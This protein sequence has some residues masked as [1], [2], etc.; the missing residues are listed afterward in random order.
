MGD[1]LG[2]ATPDSARGHGRHGAQEDV[3]LGHESAVAKVISCSAD[4]RGDGAEDAD[5]GNAADSLEKEEEEEEEEEAEG[6]RVTTVR[7]PGLARSPSSHR[8][9][10]AACDTEEQHVYCTVYC[11][12]QDSRRGGAREPG[13][14]VVP[15]GGMGSV[16]GPPASEVA[17]EMDQNPEPPGTPGVTR[18]TGVDPFYGVDYNVS[19]VL[20]CRVCLEEQRV[21]PTQCCRKAVCEDCLRAYVSSQG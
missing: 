5:F 13:G 19:V 14:G 18:L 6:E 2:H 3:D 20:T 8:E 16:E 1:E 4:G 10:G 7:A 11:L 9:Q 15:D 12:A 17:L 21:T